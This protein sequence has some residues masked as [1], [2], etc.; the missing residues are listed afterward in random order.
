MRG[1]SRG[2]WTWQQSGNNGGGDS[3]WSRSSGRHSDMQGGPGHQYAAGTPEPRPVEIRWYPAHEGIE[4]N[5]IADGGARRRRAAPPQRQLRR[6]HMPLLASLAHLN[7]EKKWK[8]ALEWFKHSTW[9]AQQKAMW[10]RVK[11]N[12]K[13]EKRKWKVAELFADEVQRGNPRDDGTLA[14]RP[15]RMR[16]QRQIAVSLEWNGSAQGASACAGCVGGRAET[17]GRTSFGSGTG[18]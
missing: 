2:H 6:R 1:K 15:R 18:W 5:E 16:I 13:R 17:G 8:E 10:A 3:R 14:G 7:G 11:K 12:A 9:R 4:G